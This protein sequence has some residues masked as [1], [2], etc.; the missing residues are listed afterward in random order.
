MV[1]YNYNRQ[2]DPPAPFVHVVLARPD[3]SGAV[4]WPAQLDTGADRSVIPPEAR[5]S[6]GL[7]ETG[8]LRVAGLGG[9]VQPMPV[10]LA[11]VGVRGL[12]QILVE[13]ITVPGERYVLLGRDLLNLHRILLDGP[14]LFFEIDE[15]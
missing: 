12:R 1:R 14:N 13:V 4:E 15:R 9:D 3:G 11:Q 5:Q 2:L 7:A 8:V 6:V 10:F